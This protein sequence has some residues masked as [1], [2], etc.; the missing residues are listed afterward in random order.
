[1]KAGCPIGETIPIGRPI[2][3]TSVRIL[4]ADRRQVARGEVGELY[5][6]GLGL[7][8]GYLNSPEATRNAFVADPFDPSAKL[9]RTGDLVRE[10]ADG[11]ID[12][13]GRADNLVKV[14][15]HRVSITEIEKKIAEVD[16]VENAI[17]SAEDDG[18]GSRWLV[19]YVQSDG[20][21]RHVKTQI[22]GA[23]KCTVPQYMIPSI[24][25][26]QPT[27]P[28]NRNGKIDRTSLRSERRVG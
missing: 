12:F 20:E 11:A 23:L 13:I 14:R 2:T 8:L 17:V 4:D 28:I 26:V 16:G 1:M 18:S 25:Y 27:L 24:I 7:A 3:G 15:G 5:T 21:P 19:A 6:G 22:A 10:L 9:Y